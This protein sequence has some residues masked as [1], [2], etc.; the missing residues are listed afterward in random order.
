MSSTSTLGEVTRES[1]WRE[2]GG[3]LI[4][5]CDMD[6]HHLLCAIRVLRNMSPI[7]TKWHG[8]PSRRRMWLNAMANEAYARGLE[9]DPLTETEPVHE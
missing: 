8:I 5:I 3:R 7:G 9:L 2:M 1:K 6:D 4:R